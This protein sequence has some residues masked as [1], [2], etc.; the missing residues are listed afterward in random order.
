MTQNTSVLWTIL[1]ARFLNNELLAPGYDQYGLSTTAVMAQIV[2]FL[3]NFILI[4]GFLMLTRRIYRYITSTFFVFNGLTNSC[5]YHCCR[6]A[7]TDFCPLIEVFLLDDYVASQ[8]LGVV[9]A[10]LLAIDL[11]WWKRDLTLLFWYYI[12]RLLFVSNIFPWASVILAVL[13]AIFNLVRNRKHYKKESVPLAVAIL[14]GLI[15]LACFPW[16]NPVFYPWT[17]ALWHIAIMTS[18][19]IFIYVTMRVEDRYLADRNKQIV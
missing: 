17:H 1:P 15:G 12:H 13:V 5:L 4:P 7:G 19:D 2:D 11:A 14:F 16:S 3:T 6:F 8:F 18:I 9:V 10:M